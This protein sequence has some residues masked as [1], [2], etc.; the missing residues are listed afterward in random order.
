MG[1]VKAT[2]GITNCRPDVYDASAGPSN[3]VRLRQRGLRPQPKRGQPRT[4]V[5]GSAPETP[6]RGS[7]PGPGY[8][9]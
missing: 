9:I 6:A 1:R 2:A 7:A 4:P 5:G 3:R 8:W